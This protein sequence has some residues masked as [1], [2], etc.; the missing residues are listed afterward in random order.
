MLPE[1][2]ER[3]GGKKRAIAREALRQ[4]QELDEASTEE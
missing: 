2:M 3:I 4:L 1:E